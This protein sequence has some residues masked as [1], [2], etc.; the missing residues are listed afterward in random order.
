V[1]PESEATNRL[2]LGQTSRITYDP[3]KNVYTKCDLC[4]W[5][6]EGPACVQACPVNVRIRQG[7][8]KSDRLC[9]DAPASTREHWQEQ[10]EMDWAVNL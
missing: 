8:I 6:E 9:L 10:S 5:R 3:V 2:A 7:I 4:F 1:L